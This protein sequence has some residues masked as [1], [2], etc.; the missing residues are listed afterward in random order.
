MGETDCGGFG[1]VGWG[2]DAWDARGR[3]GEE[4]VLDLEVSELVRY[5]GSLFVE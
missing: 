3:G 4:G 1:G 5:Q 2:V